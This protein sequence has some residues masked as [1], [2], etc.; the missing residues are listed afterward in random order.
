[1]LNSMIWPQQFRANGPDFRPNC[2]GDQLSQPIGINDLCPAIKK[3][4]NV[5][6]NFTKGYSIQS[7]TCTGT[8]PA[9]SYSRRILSFT[10]KMIK[11]LV[12]ILTICNKYLNIAI[13]CS[14]PDAGYE[15]C[16]IVAG[17]SCL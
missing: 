16:Y 1:M 8:R 13:I 10:R 9:E 5:A 12:L 3:D 17:P 14:L 2:V 4:N 11:P 6:T 15:G 7:R